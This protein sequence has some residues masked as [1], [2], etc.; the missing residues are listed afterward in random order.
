MSH[1]HTGFTHF[2][3]Q[4]GTRQVFKQVCA[5]S[6][7]K[8]AMGC[9]EFRE[10]GFRFWADVCPKHF[11]TDSPLKNK[12]VACNLWNVRSQRPH[13]KKVMS[14]NH[15]PNCT[16]CSE[17][18]NHNSA[19]GHCQGIMLITWTRAIRTG[20]L[21]NWARH[22]ALILKHKVILQKQK[23]VFTVWVHASIQLSRSILLLPYL[24]L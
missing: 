18:R 7:S 8:L 10:I 23:T 21:M 19:L 16:K 4:R 9:K 14:H 2:C 24:L 5:H 13:W 15:T 6:R 20:Q 1:Y 17:N 22:Y 3:F 12:T 11:I